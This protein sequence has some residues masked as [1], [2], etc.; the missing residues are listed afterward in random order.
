MKEI[1]IV[2]LKTVRESSVPYGHDNLNEP[3]NAANLSARSS[4]IP[5]G[6]YL[7]C[8]RRTTGSGL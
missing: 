1:P 8:A 4:M 2:K 5:T 7:P 6:K 3:A